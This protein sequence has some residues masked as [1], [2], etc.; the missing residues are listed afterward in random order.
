MKYLPET[1][2]SVLQ[3]T[4]TDF[5]VLIIN[6]GSDDDIVQWASGLIDPRVKLISQANQGV[7]V[8]RN[9]GIAHSQ[10]NY[11]AFLDADDLWEPTKL[12]KQVR[13]LDDHPE[14]GLVHTWMM[15]IDCQGKPTGRVIASHAE[16][17]VWKQLVEWN[18]IAC[19][20]VM[21]RR[22]CFETVGGFE[23]NL[24]FVEDW[25]MWI[26]I[27]RHYL[28]AVLKE[29]LYYYRQVPN[30]LSKNFQ[31]LEQSCTFVIEKAFNCAPAELL[32]LKSHSYGYTNICLAWKALQTTD[33]DFQRALHFCQEAIAHY[34][35]LRSSREYMRLRL[36]IAALQ[37]FGTD[38]YGKV[39]E[40]AY[41][42]RRRISNLTQL[43]SIRSSNVGKSTQSVN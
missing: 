36:A 21:V 19:S 2:E 3:Q 7:S 11:I 5:E 29:C 33:K 15:L 18:Q 40:L 14:V 22:C 23:P 43:N 13:C 28:F 10:A 27:S 41:S 12:E 30:S 39:L 24:H 25:D 38:G 6:D 37:L 4:L 34:P 16:G 32:Y 42:V 9:T 8:A 20:S 1:L 31:V 35:K 26:R 17:D